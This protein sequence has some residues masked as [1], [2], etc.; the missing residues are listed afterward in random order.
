M[1][2]EPNGFLEFF[3]DIPLFFKIFGGTLFVLVVGVFLYVIIFGL[4][5]WFSNNAAELMH[6]SATVIDKR[7]EVW[8][9]S[10]DS[11]ANTNY[12]ITFQFDDQSRKEL[13]IPVQHFGMIVVGDFGELSYQGTRFKEFKRLT[14]AHKV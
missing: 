12:F 2:E 4:K 9:G 8:G 11:S 10:G 14:D 3:A 1:Y 7:T 6:Q 13:P 5:S